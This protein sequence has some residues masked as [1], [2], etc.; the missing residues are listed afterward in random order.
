MPSKLTREEITVP[1][2][3]IASL[4][5]ESN[6]AIAFTGAGVST[7]S[8]IPDFRSPKTGLWN[9][10]EAR[11]LIEPGAFRKES[12]TLDE[13]MDL[14]W[15]VG[16]KLGKKILRAKPNKVHKILAGWEERGIIKG[17]I[18]QNVDMLHQRAGSKNVIELHGNAY[19]VTC[20]FCRGSYRLED[21]LRR[22][23]WM[24]K[25]HAPWCDSCAG[26]IKPNVVMFGDN[27]PRDEMDKARSEIKKTDLVLILGSSLLVYPAN[28]LPV[29][30]R[31]HGG[32]V[33]IINDV[34]TDLDKISEVVI[35]G[36]IKPIIKKINDFLPS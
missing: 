24:K 35:N 32:K 31:K 5:A 13:K 6:H 36:P 29:F 12:L 11:K 25:K 23:K 15:R 21:I 33:V 9:Q 8:G 16:Y 1:A 34:E 4:L 14:F 26:L 17:I 2:K 28:S 27:I 7:D 18:T 3:E 20:M 22:Y 19:E 10:I 30:V